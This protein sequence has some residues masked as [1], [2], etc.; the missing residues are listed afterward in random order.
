LSTA[1]QAHSEV[2]MVYSWS[3]F[4]KA[5]NGVHFDLNSGNLTFDLRNCFMPDRTLPNVCCFDGGASD[6]GCFSCRR[7]I[8][9]DYVDACG[10]DDLLFAIY[11]IFHLLHD[12]LLSESDASLAATADS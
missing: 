8:D 12:R 6:F 3:S 5:G 10:Y 7:C 4:I 9:R 11:S 2:K 1:V